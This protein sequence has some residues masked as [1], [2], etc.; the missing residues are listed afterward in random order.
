MAKM[1]TYNGIPWRPIATMTNSL[2]LFTRIADI[3]VETFRPITIKPLG[4]TDDTDKWLVTYRGNLVHVDPY[5][6]AR[7][8]ALTT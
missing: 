1:H 3:L 4:K 7:I 2:V 8:E 5:R 6:S